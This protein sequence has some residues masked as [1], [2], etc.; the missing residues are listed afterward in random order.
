VVLFMGTSLSLTLSPD[1]DR[2]SL[3]ASMELDLGEA[4][5]TS[6]PLFVR[7]PLLVSVCGVLSESEMLSVWRVFVYGVSSLGCF[8]YMDA[9][10]ILGG[11]SLMRIMILRGNEFRPALR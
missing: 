11:G 5:Q 9:C 10:W 4:H 7:Q 1:L 2:G 6:V 3:T 8:L